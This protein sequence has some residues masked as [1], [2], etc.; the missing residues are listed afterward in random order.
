M[1]LKAILVNAFFIASTSFYDDFNVLEV[2][3]LAADAQLHIE[4]FF[5]LLGWRLK[6]L[7]GFAP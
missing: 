4:R 2:E 1:G 3:A 7:D 6:A 5:E